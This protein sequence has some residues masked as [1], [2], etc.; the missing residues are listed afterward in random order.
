VPSSFLY[1]KERQNP[2]FFIPLPTDSAEEA[3]KEAK[4]NKPKINWQ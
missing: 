4:S 3:T 1:T 2:Y